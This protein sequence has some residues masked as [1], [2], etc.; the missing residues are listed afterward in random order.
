MRVLLVGPANSGKM[1]LANFFEATT[2]PLRKVASI[3][4]YKKTIIVPDSYLESPWMHKHII[5][6]QQS[7]DCG[8]FLQPIEAQR[9]SY[10]PNFANV[11]RIPL[12]GVL[13]HQKKYTHKE[14]QQAAQKLHLCGLEHIALTI[15][16][17]QEE[18]NQIEKLLGR[19]RKNES[20]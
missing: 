6:L 11:F 5:S 1:A 13:T 7:A 14:W 2:E 4:Y 17:N 15:D 18:F 9:N 20:F 19:G 10:P 3:V 12:Y 8:L 16:L